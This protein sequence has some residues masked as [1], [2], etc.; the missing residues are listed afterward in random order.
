MT[1]NPELFG[2]NRLSNYSHHDFIK[3]YNVAESNEE[4]SQVREKLKRIDSGR[5]YDVLDEAH[6]H[7]ARADLEGREHLQGLHSEA[8]LRWIGVFGLVEDLNTFS[9]VTGVER[10]Q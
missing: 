2:G 7:Y 4:R 3:A 6:D 10:E 9:D 5:W 8:F 1:E